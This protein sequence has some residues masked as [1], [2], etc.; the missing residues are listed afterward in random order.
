MIPQ[1]LDLDF[2]ATEYTGDA[3]DPATTLINAVRTELAAMGWTEPVANTMVSPAR[4]DDLRLSIALSKISNTRVAYVVKDKYGRLINNNT[5]CRQDI[6]AGNHFTVYCGS[7]Y[8]YVCV[9]GGYF[10]HACCLH[11]EPDTLAKPFPVYL[12]SRC[13]ANDGSTSYSAWYLAWGAWNGAGTTAINIIANIAHSY[14]GVDFFTPHMTMC[15]R[16]AEWTESTWY[17]GRMPNLLVIDASQAGGTEF[18]VPLDETHI[19]T[20]RVLDHAANAYNFKPA[21]RVA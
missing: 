13:I 10:W 1:F 17:L 9:T 6:G 4:T 7:Y 8:L 2:R 14:N 15:F 5:D 21:V 19:G 18:T 12:V 20:F 11:R 3:T 16:P